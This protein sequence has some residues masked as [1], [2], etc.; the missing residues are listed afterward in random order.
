MSIFTHASSTFAFISCSPCIYGSKHSLFG[1]LRHCLSGVQ[2]TSLTV[3]QANM[4]VPYSGQFHCHKFTQ[5]LQIQKFHLK[6]C[7][8]WKS[9]LLLDVIV[10]PWSSPSIMNVWSAWCALCFIHRQISLKLSWLEEK[11]T[12]NLTWTCLTWRHWTT[13]F[14]AECGMNFYP[15]ITQEHK[16]MLFFHAFRIA[17]CRE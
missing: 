3:M 1:W 8:N 4:C 13:K 2:I 6:F 7:L 5:M 10:T 11:L 15:K 17:L 16:H 9:T 12:C 14:V